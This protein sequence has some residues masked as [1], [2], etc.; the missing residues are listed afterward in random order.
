MLGAGAATASCFALL[1]ARAQARAGAASTEL[2]TRDGT[3]RDLR[4]TAEATQGRLQTADEALAS[5]HAARDR[6]QAELDDVPRQAGHRTAG[7]RTNAAAG[8]THGTET[9]LDGF[10]TCAAGSKDPM[11][12]R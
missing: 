11:C 1:S 8:Q 2:A 6:V 7:P 12:I 9:K 4:A 10:T 5:M 3:I